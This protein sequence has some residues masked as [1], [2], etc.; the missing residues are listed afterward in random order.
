MVYW[1]NAVHHAGVASECNIIS[2][3]PSKKIN[4][5]TTAS[6]FVIKS[7]YK[8]AFL[9]QCIESLNADKETHQLP[10]DLSKKACYRSFSTE[11]S[12]YLSIHLSILRFPSP[13]PSILLG[14]SLSCSMMS[15]QSLSLQVLHM[16]TSNAVREINSSLFPTVYCLYILY[17]ILFNLAD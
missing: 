16:E 7:N 6:P 13:P 2:T 14:G 1:C 15:W 3:S 11:K 17:V 9:W 8:R 5:S 12:H 4:S 10:T